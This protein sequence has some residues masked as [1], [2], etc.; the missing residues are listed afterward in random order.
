MVIPLSFNI[1]INIFKSRFFFSLKKTHFLKEKKSITFNFPL[2]NHNNNTNNITS[3][4]QSPSI[5]HSLFQHRCRI[6][7]H[8]HHTRSFT[9]TTSTELL[10][11]GVCSFC[12]CCVFVAF[13]TSVPL[14]VHAVFLF[15]S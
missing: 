15:L 11:L 7:N 9:T 8:Q 1:F 10:D 5:S 4:S 2:I 3:L 12:S 6:K 13:L 14:P